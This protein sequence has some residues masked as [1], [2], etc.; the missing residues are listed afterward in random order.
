MIFSKKAFTLVELIVVITILAVLWTIS[1][2]SFQ[3]YS[4]NARDSKRISEVWSIKKVLEFWVL[5]K[6]YYEYPQDVNLVFYS[7]SIAWIQWYFWDE[8]LSKYGPWTWISKVPTDP[9]LWNYYTYSLL[10]NRTEYQLAYMLENN[11]ANILKS[12]NVI[13]SDNIWFAKITW[14]YNS[15]ILTIS[16]WSYLDVIATPSI[17]SSDLDDSDLSSLI[18]NNKLT[19]DNWKN[20]P[21]SYSDFWYNVLSD[22]DKNIINPS[23]YLIYSWDKNLLNSSDLIDNIKLAYSWVYDKSLSSDISS[24]ISL[25]DSLVWDTLIDKYIN[26]SASSKKISYWS[27]NNWYTFLDANK[28]PIYP[29]S[30]KNL[31]DNNSF[32]N[33]ELGSPYNWS[34]FKSWK[35]YV[36]VWGDSFPVYCDMDTDWWGW[37]MIVSADSEKDIISIEAA[38]LFDPINSDNMNIDDE[39]ISKF[40]YSSDWSDMMVYTRWYKVK[41]TNLNK[42]NISLKWYTNIDYPWNSTASNYSAVTTADDILLLWNQWAVQDKAWNWWKIWMWINQSWN[43]WCE[44]THLHFWPWYVPQWFATCRTSQW[45][46]NNFYWNDKQ[47]I[48]ND[49]SSASMYKQ[50]W[51]IR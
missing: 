37:T 27:Y 39:W 4:S 18:I 23:S 26:K 35:Y 20:L 2:M 9:V 16:S 21:Y 22:N 25:W 36:K 46:M 1:F 42:Q 51:F 43:D 10:P 12:N 34:S 31:L 49:W 44:V 50:N 3:W 14:T 29:T 7:W 13:A 8:V 24:I 15:K 30:C 17:I 40:I 38:H 19:F 47:W 48:S 45:K 32:R 28:N 6:G 41:W 5:K 11:Q 33:S